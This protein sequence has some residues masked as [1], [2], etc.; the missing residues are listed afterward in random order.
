MKQTPKENTLPDEN[1]WNGWVSF[2]WGLAWLT[3]I[4]SIVMVFTLGYI[5]VK[6]PNLSSF[7]RD[8]I[9]TYTEKHFNWTV[10]VWAT[11]QT[12]A[13]FLFAALLSIAHASYK[14]S[15]K[16]MRMLTAVAKLTMADRA[17]AKREQPVKTAITE[18]PPQN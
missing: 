9:P 4:A 3:A 1:R 17:K 2:A 18:Q 16:T 15:C 5:E 8:I 6:V 12:V 14:N 13:A 7:T 11:G 10:L